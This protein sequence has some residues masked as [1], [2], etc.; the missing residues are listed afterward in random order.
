MKTA[1]FKLFFILI[2][3]IDLFSYKVLAQDKY[4]Q[5]DENKSTNQW[6]IK[7]S[8]FVRNDI[9]FD[10]RQIVNAREGELELFPA[11]IAKDV[12]GLDKNAASS[13]NILSITS[14][15]TGTLTGPDAFGAKTSGIIEG[16]FFGNGNSV[17]E[18]NLFRM[19]HAYAQLDW[20]KTKL[21]FGQYWHP[22]YNFECAPGQL[23]FNAG[24]PFVPFNRSPQVRLTQT[25]PHNFQLIVAAIAER[26]FTSIIP[27]NNSGLASF[28]T[29]G[30]NATEGIRNASIPN[31]HTQVIYKK[32]NAMFGVAVD[33]KMLRPALAVGT[34][35]GIISN[36]TVSSFSFE[37]YGKMIT[38]NATVKASFVSGQNLTDQLMLGGYVAYGTYSAT[39]ASIYYQS[40]SVNSYWIDISGNG[41]KIIPGLFMGYSKNN[42]SNELNGIAAYGR[43][44]GVSGRGIN[45]IMRVSPRVEFVSGKF[46]IGTELEITTAAYGNSISNAKVTGNTDAVTNI[47]GLFIT[48]FLF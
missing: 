37:V 11:D 48:T 2:I 13:F 32:A 46:K 36:A 6:S 4:L 40:T 26:D 29:A 16:E 24:M 9:F 15:I 22:L 33:W 38:R 27:S 19:R 25:F 14:R 21:G 18:G 39:T 30:V 43:G 42:G 44:I 31:L 5:L 7:Y 20:G 34:A 10:S 1:S 45:D 47:R 17:Y 12:N 8:G 35:P 23:S 28:T 3:M 41:K